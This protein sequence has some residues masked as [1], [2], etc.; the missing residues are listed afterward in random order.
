MKWSYNSSWEGV[1]Y[2]YDVT[3]QYITLYFIINEGFRATRSLAANNCIRV[4][5]TRPWQRLYMWTNEMEFEFVVGGS[6]I[7]I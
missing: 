6:G 5:H 2:V 7:C 1:L 3:H 4:G